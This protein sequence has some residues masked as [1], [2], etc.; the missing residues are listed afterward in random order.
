MK[1]VQ[2]ALVISLGISSSLGSVCTARAGDDAF[3]AWASS[4]LVPL[5]TVKPGAPWDDLAPLGKMI[6]DARIVAL[7]EGV[8]AGAEPLDFRNRVFQYLVRE[9]GFTA[10]AIE[11]GIV[12]GRTVHDYVRD[13]RGEL[14]EVLAQGLTWTFDKL[15]QNE[16]LVR[17]IREYNADAGHTKKINFYGFDVPGSPGNPAA[18]RGTET[19]LTE[20]LKYV[21]RVD[22][23]AGAAFH[24][25]LDALLPS[26]KFDPRSAE[27]PGYPK[28][29]QAE[30]D[31]VSAGIA[32]LVTLLERREAPYIAAS[33]AA[34][35]QWAHR[36][37]IGARQID[38]WLRQIPLNWKA[39][40]SLAAFFAAATDVR[41]R[42]QADNIDWVMKQ[43]GASGKLLVFASRYHLSAVPLR[44]SRKPD[45]AGPWQEVAGTYLRRRYGSQFVN[46]GNL[47]LEGS[48]GCAGFWMDLQRAGKGSID[49]IAGELGKPLFL[50]DTRAA[51]ESAAGW[52]AREHQ[53]GEAQTITAQ[54]GR[55]YDIFF[56][57][58]RVSAACSRGSSAP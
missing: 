36:A 11:S 8:H 35:Y 31:T 9:K 51:P 57:M 32:D 3:R 50:L 7:S 14:P 42:G 18:N 30:R 21:S 17:W 5:S 4:A 26:V 41:D 37:A 52:L 44:T 25:R 13:G 39:S 40:D 6:G 46:V 10:I 58:D 53:F 2:A 29:T 54:A 43:E 16:A 20:V 15:P 27:K 56:Y 55:A 47:I 48:L 24:A 49:G 28:L 23:E 38:G 33:S 19:A 45:Q 1:M 34:D 22:S 12:E